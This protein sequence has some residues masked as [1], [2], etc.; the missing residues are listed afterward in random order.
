MT[1]QLNSEDILKIID[2]NKINN[3]TK[4]K[5]G[6]PKKTHNFS[7]NMSK[8]KLNLN[9]KIYDEDEEIILH[10]PIS[11]SD[12]KLLKNNDLSFD[13]LNN[14]NISLDNQE[15]S[16]NNITDDIQHTSKTN[17]INDKDMSHI[18]TK[19]YNNII[20]QEASESKKLTDKDTL[21]KK[22]K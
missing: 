13:D 9:E 3:D 12:I 22:L 18:Y 21:N 7:N 11:K 15:L 8:I 6:R 19:Q 1:T 17:I 4:K 5:R 14:K 2:L 20:F 10:L 16:E